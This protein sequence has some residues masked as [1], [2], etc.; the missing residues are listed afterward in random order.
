MYKLDKAVHQTVDFEAEI[1][2]ITNYLALK[3][4]PIAGLRELVAKVRDAA[5]SAARGWV[6]THEGMQQARA[7]KLKRVALLNE[8]LPT[9]LDREVGPGYDVPAAKL[10]AITYGMSDLHRL[11][12]ELDGLWSFDRRSGQLYRS[13]LEAYPGLGEALPL[14]WE[15][16][17]GADSDFAGQ[18]EYDSKADS[19]LFAGADVSGVLS[20][21]FVLRTALPYVR[22]DVQGQGF[23]AGE[24]LVGAVLG[25]FLLLVEWQNTQA[26]CRAIRELDLKLEEPQLVFEVSPTTDNPHLAALLAMV[27]HRDKVG[28][29]NY[30][31]FRTPEGY[32]EALRIKLRYRA[33]TPEEKA[34]ADRED[35]AETEAIL[36]GVREKV[37]AGPSAD[38][39]ECDAIGRAVL[40]ERL[41][42]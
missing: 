21:N 42:H 23:S 29:R 28:E 7:L 18:E 2:A 15:T 25:Q 27:A 26:L 3:W 39:L 40:L 13:L 10:D 6:G 37:L 16:L 8:C 38:E 17:A 22:Y 12:Q 4:T 33:M 35:E 19:E 34:I 14:G 9:P 36:S 11:G 32:A 31:A 41:G 30:G 24:V 5:V 20:G 1:D